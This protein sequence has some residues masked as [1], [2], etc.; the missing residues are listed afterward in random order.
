MKMIYNN[1]DGLDVSFQGA[2]PE[3]ILIS[4]AQ[5]K[6]L[7]KAAHNDDVV[8]KIGRSSVPVA[9]AATGA[10]GGYAYRFD[11]GVDGA[12]W[13]VK[14]STKRNDWNIRVSLKSLNLALNGYEKARDNLFSMLDDFGVCGC[15]YNL[16]NELLPPEQSV[17]RVDYC[18]DFLID[19]FVLE[20]ENF[21]A[22][23]RSTLRGVE[24]IEMDTV[25]R[26][27]KMESVTVGKMPNRQVI[28]YDKTLEIRQK[29]KP[30]WW[31]I[32]NLKKE[33]VTGK[34]WR[35]EIRAGK[36]ELREWNIASFDALEFCMGDALQRILEDI[37]YVIPADDTNRSRWPLHPLWESCQEKAKE[38][39]AP[40]TSNAERRKIIKD[41]RENIV[42]R[43]QKNLRGSIAT[44]N[45]LL[46][47]SPNEVVK[48]LGVITEDVSAYA[49][50][51]DFLKKIK[52]AEDKYV[53]LNDNN[54]KE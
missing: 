38:V 21:L 44:Y 37:R 34:I 52:K 24:P 11:T 51:G 26:A 45:H 35:I 29:Q 9:V 23:S 5:T 53:F 25:H 30:F 12:T 15:F 6:E 47:H 33:E 40:Y 14:H 3:D 16:E 27:N 39:L 10:K 8:V 50:H 4:L 42:T 46:G 48:T 32:W 1:F 43:A 17:G 41:L 20:A 19:D 54:E 31:D 36:N 18:F 13:F 2:F 7:T 28:I 22:H 49:I